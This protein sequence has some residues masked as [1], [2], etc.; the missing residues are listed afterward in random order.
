MVANI[1]NYTAWYPKIPK[2]AKVRFLI[3]VMIFIYDT[4][5][6]HTQP[7]EGIL[8]KMDFIILLADE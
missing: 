3:W 4:L 5:Y 6:F 7:T 8:H 1:S 2:R